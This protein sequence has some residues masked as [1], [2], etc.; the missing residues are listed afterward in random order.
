MKPE[1]GCGRR[2]RLGPNVGQSWANQAGDQRLL[3]TGPTRRQEQGAHPCR[4]HGIQG[5]ACSIFTWEVERQGTCSGPEVDNHRNPP[6]HLQPHIATL[7]PSRNQNRACVKCV[8]LTSFS[9][10]Q[11]DVHTGYRVLWPEFSLIGSVGTS[12]PFRFAD[13]QCCIVKL[14]ARK[15]SACFISTIGFLM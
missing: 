6:Y 10:W 4:A 13:F 7:T 11:S 2:A 1:P 15:L 5:Q 9:D 8:A 12:S 3:P 14:P